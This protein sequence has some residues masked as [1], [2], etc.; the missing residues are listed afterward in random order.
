MTPLSEIEEIDQDAISTQK[1]FCTGGIPI[2]AEVNFVKHTPDDPRRCIAL[3]HYDYGVLEGQELNFID[4]QMERI[5]YR[6]VAPMIYVPTVEQQKVS[7]AEKQKLTQFL[8]QSRKEQLQG[9]VCQV[10]GKTF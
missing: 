5:N 3:V 6:R 7:E 2:I 10:T 9:Y 8:E 1:H 4:Q